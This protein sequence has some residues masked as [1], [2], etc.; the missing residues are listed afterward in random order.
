MSLIESDVEE[1]E[2]KMAVVPK[3][4]FNRL[5]IK[6]NLNSPPSNWLFPHPSGIDAIFRHVDNV[7]EAVKMAARLHDLVLDVDVIADAE[8]VKKLLKMP[9]KS[10]SYVSMMVHCVANKALVVDD[11]DVR[12][13][14]QRDDVESR[15]FSDKLFDLEAKSKALGPRSVINNDTMRQRNLLSKFYYRSVEKAE[16]RTQKAPKAAKRSVLWNFE[17]IR[18][19]IGSDMPIF[20]DEKH[21]SVSLRLHDMQKPINVLTGMDYWLDN[22]MCQVPEV[23]MCYHLDGFV[24]KY[25]LLKTEDVPRIE[26]CKFSPGVVQDV[27]RNILSFLK[28][29]CTKEGHTYWLFKGK[30]DDVV[31]L[32]DLTSLY[33]SDENDANPFQTPVS[34]LLYRVAKNILEGADS[35]RHDEATAKQL[36]ENCLNLLDEDRFPDIA[37]KANLYLADIYLPQA[38]DPNNPKFNEWP[39]ASPTSSPPPEM[40]ESVHSVTTESLMRHNLRRPMPSTMKGDIDYCWFA[41]RE[42]ISALSRQHGLLILFWSANDLYHS[43]RRGPMRLWKLDHNEHT[44]P[45]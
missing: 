29:N 37:A 25:E 45:A 22:L 4:N 8:S 19:L 13:F 40:E 14:L 10:A 32:Y 23:L 3:A 38:T 26:G 12:R 9:F 5:E 42:N 16:T 41:K 6:T 39:A 24:Q 44:K 34:L 43:L 7:A 36:L 20:G 17:D 18:M 31:K 15:R 21:P 33:K 11:F 27:A 2:N 28:T 35:R 1:E 30:E